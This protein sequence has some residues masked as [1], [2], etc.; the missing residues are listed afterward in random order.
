M[1]KSFRNISM[2]LGFI[3]FLASCT[4]IPPEIP[5]V[6]LE[7]NKAVLVEDFTGVRCT[8]CPTA[9]QQIN[10]LAQRY[11]DKVIP[12][13]IH[14]PKYSSF[15][16]PHVNSVY[17]FRIDKADAIAGLVENEIEGLPSAMFDRFDFDMGGLKG[18]VVSSVSDYASALEE[19]LQEEAA[20][21]LS[22]DNDY[23]ASTRKLTSTALIRPA[24]ELEGEVFITFMLLEDGI[25]DVQTD[26]Q[27]LIEAY[28]HNYVLRDIFSQN[29]TGDLI[30]QPLQK[31]ELIEIRRS[32]QIP[33]MEEGKLWND[34][35]SMHT[36]VVLHRKGEVLT[37]LQA[38]KA[39]LLEQ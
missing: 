13:S 17:D 18:H 7:G 4:E 27:A 12:V 1:M 24:E 19:R 22:I 33:E 23:D 5:P 25:I 38:A 15:T 30:T 35:E 11:G 34:P 21:L 16:T 36:V 9:A 37:C 32:V 29:P 6:N 2:A 31:G 8:N 28:E 10:N 14:A 3:F 26:K 39:S 20:F